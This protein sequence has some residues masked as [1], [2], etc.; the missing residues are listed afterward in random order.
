MSCIAAAEGH[1]C[2]NPGAY[3]YVTHDGGKTWNVTGSDAGGGAMGACAVMYV[4]LQLPGSWPLWA[5]EMWR[6]SFAGQVVRFGSEVASQDTVA[7]CR[8]GVASWMRGG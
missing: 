6:G 7:R 4:M 3:F 1:N 5:P 8:A 2:A